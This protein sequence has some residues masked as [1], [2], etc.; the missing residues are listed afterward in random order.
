M[1]LDDDVFEA[2]YFDMVAAA[3]CSVQGAEE[4][5]LHHIKILCS[6]HNAELPPQLGKWLVDRFPGKR[7][8]R[9]RGE[10][11]WRRDLRLARMVQEYIAAGLGPTRAAEAA[12]EQLWADVREAIALGVALG[13]PEEE[14]VIR[15]ARI[16][17]PKMHDLI[18]ERIRAGIPPRQ[19]FEKLHTNVSHG[20]VPWLDAHYIARQ[21]KQIF[22]PGS[23]S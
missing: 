7:P 20:D 8:G 3:R 18:T 16:L 9:K 4:R 17:G 1:L 19:A 14:V 10:L 11:T 12:W 13:E 5:L 22:G 2:F 23:K 15:Q 6:Q 21:H